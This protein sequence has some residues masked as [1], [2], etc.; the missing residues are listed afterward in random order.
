MLTPPLDEEGQSR[1]G[2]PG[3][4]S[5]AGRGRVDLQV[6]GAHALP[7]DVA[8]HTAVEPAVSLVNL[9]DRSYVQEYYILSFNPLPLGT[10]LV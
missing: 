8:R 1:D 4:G 5:Q 3:P 2:Q 9:P 7:Q 6:G 10:S